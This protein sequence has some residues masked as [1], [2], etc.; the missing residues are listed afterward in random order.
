MRDKLG[1]KNCERKRE[2]E[3]RKTGKK[4]GVMYLGRK[5]ERKEESRKVGER[6]K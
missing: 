3:K 5:K 2:R 4:R 6:V 1:K